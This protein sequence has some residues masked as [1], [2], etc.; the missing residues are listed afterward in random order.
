MAQVVLADLNAG[1]QAPAAARPVLA[2]ARLDGVARTTT[3]REE[4]RRIYN[5]S[6]ERPSG[7]N[8]CTCTCRVHVNKGLYTAT[9]GPA[10]AALL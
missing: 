1:M 7:E 5:P 4:G 2:H 6:G 10:A 8:T 3:V 9:S